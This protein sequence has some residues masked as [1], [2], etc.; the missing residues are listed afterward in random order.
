MNSIPPFLW[1]IGAYCDIFCF[2]K[3]SGYGE[4][5][6]KKSIVPAIIAKG[7]KELD[8]IFLKISGH[9]EM[10]QLDVMDGHFVPNQSLDFDFRLPQKKYRYEAHLMVEDPDRWIESF[11]DRV[12]TIIAHFES[13][14]TSFKTIQAI[15]NLG[16]K[17]ALALNPETNIEEVSGYL[18][19]IDQVLIMTVHP[20]FYG[21]P[22]LPEV[23]GKIRTLR[24]IRPEMDIEVDGGIKPQTIEMVDEAGANLFVA[25]SYLINSENIQERISLLRKKLIV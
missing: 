17:A 4:E 9:A 6:M 14:A 19:S 11:G 8:E 3:Q 10:V 15:K 24:Q 16:K 22:F 18:N 23:M 13:S 5:R 25:G 1:I 21:S 2:E 7:Q 20:G 12:D